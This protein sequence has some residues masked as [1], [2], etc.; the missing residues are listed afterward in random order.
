MS[1]PAGTEMFQF[2]AFASATYGFSDG[3]L[4]ED[5]WVSPFGHP[6]IQGCLPP[7][8][9]LS[10]ATTSFIACCR[11][12]IHQMRLFTCPYNLKRSRIRS[13]RFLSPL[14]IQNDW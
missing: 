1:V 12:G 10:Q 3:Y 11:Q 8:R 5:R 14:S 6:R 2:S 7:P 9:G 4:S 13:Y